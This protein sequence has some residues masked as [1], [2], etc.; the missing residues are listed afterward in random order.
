MTLTP[1]AGYTQKVLCLDPK[2]VGQPDRLRFFVNVL[3]T[4]AN[5]ALAQNEIAYFDDVEVSTDPSCPA[6]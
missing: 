4:C 2:R 1:A 3:G 5:P 6:Q